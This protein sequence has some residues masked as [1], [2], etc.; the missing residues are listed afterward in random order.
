MTG[1]SVLQRLGNFD[2]DNTQIHE[3]SKPDGKHVKPTSVQYICC[4][5]E[6]LL[7]FL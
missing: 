5:N 2:T 7:K 6:L 1:C 3:S 4:P